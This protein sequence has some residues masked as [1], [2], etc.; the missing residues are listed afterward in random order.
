MISPSLYFLSSIPANTPVFRRRNT[1]ITYAEYRD[2]T[3]AL[4][5]ELERT[6]A[7]TAVLMTEDNYQF[8]VALFAALHAG[9]SVILP[10]NM[11]TGTAKQLQAEGGVLVSDPAELVG[12][13]PILGHP[14][15]NT[16]LRPFD[17][18][19]ADVWFYTSGS[20]GTPKRIHRTFATLEAELHLL[21]EVLPENEQ[22][23]VFTTS[24][25][26]HAYGIIFGF[27][28]PLSRGLLSDTTSFHSPADFL[29][30]VDS[31]ATPGKLAWIV[32]TPAFIR[33]WADNPDVCPLNH[34]P[35]RIQSA[36]AP[37][38]IRAAQQLHTLTHAE[39]FEIF[40]SSETGVAAHRNPLNTEEWTPFRSVR[41]TPV[42]E[43]S[44][45]IDS[46]CI[47]PGEHA[48]PGDN[49]K[50]LPNGNFL[51]LPRADNVVKIADKRISLAEVEQHLEACPLVKRAFALKLEGKTR[52]I[53]AAVVIPSADGY[54]LLRS[55]GRQAL[56]KQLAAHLGQR[57]PA[58]LIPKKWRFS[59]EVPTNAQGKTEWATLHRFF[60]A[61]DYTPILTPQETS[62]ERLLARALYPVDAPWVAG[63]FPR[64]AITPGVV[65][66]RTLS[67]LTERYWGA[68]ITRIQRLKFSAEVTPGD[69]IYIILERSGD[70][71][72]V[73]LSRTPDGKTPTGKGNC[74][75]SPMP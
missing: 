68:T 27:L 49:A 73:L 32:T 43:G 16:E 37:L 41:L 29:A 50:L 6:G 23:E 59:G 26:H 3:A 20:S 71:L 17:A 42:Q 74:R 69:E 2:H 55:R 53:L 58:V 62:P 63:H 64:H 39:F 54:E 21:A 8:A 44:M 36:G 66:L 51:L 33:V 19:A 47:P 28:L 60:C 38:P 1:I 67:L 35:L 56:R 72:S 45:R 15:G 4:A 52:P 70:K 10:G 7:K 12:A 61:K 18:T 65:I 9:M 11:S 25:F 34:R 13:I 31:L 40:G 14:T 75:L 48:T 22:A 57:L 5:A 30:R 46:P 24:F